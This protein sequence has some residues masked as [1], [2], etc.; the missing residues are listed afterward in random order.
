[1]QK[2]Y[3]YKKKKKRKERMSRQSIMRQGIS[4]NGSGLFSASCL[5]LGGGPVSEGACTPSGT[6]CRSLRFW[7]RDGI[8][9]HLP[10]WHCQPQFLKK[11]KRSSLTREAPWITAPWLPSFFMV[12]FSSSTMPPP[13]V[14]SAVWVESSCLIESSAPG[15]QSGELV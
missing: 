5:L 3:G 4:E 11:R 9:V 10:S 15:L 8:C 14:Y 1:M 12:Y 13:D 6:P 7:V 2:S